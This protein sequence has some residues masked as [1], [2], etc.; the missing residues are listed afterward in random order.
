MIY[1]IQFGFQCDYTIKCSM[2]SYNFNLKWNEC[3]QDEESVNKYRTACQK[4]L[5]R[6]MMMIPSACLWIHT[7]HTHIFQTNNIE[8]MHEHANKIII[9][10]LFVSDY[11]IV[12]FISSCENFFEIILHFMN[13]CCCFLLE[14]Y[15]WKPLKLMRLHK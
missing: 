4:K 15:S 13:E 6:Q 1:Y 9:R 2:I 10:I 12:D 3:K 14:F 5:M 7:L 11:F 8:K